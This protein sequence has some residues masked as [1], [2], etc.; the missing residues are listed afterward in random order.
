MPVLTNL[1]PFY[2]GLFVDQN[3]LWQAIVMI[4]TTTA[5]NRIPVTFGINTGELC[6]CLEQILT[7]PIHFLLG[8]YS[9][10]TSTALKI[11]MMIKTI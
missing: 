7:F 6:V 3:T 9:G 1:C 5:H 8:P 10:K 4:Q 11:M 2:T